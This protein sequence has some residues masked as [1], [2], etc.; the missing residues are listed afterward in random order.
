ML[1]ITL[2]D[3]TSSFSIDAVRSKIAKFQNTDEYQVEVDKNL[4]YIRQDLNEKYSELKETNDVLCGIYQKL[5]ET[6]KTGLG[7]AED[8]RETIDEIRQL[9]QEMEEAL[10]NYATTGWGSGKTFEEMF[11]E[12]FMPFIEALDALADPISQLG[13]GEIPLINQ[14]PELIKKFMTMGKIV[15]KLP[16]EIRNQAIAQAKQAKEEL[17]KSYAEQREAAGA[18][19]TWKRLEYDY[20]NSDSIVWRLIREIVEIV[21]A[22]FEM[23]EAICSCIEIFAILIIIDKFKPVIDQFKIMVGDA[24]TILENVETLLKCLIT[25]KYSMLK[26]LGKV[27]WSKIEGLIDFFTYVCTDMD[28]PSNALI[29]ACYM[30]LISCQCDISSLQLSVDYFE[31]ESRATY[32]KNAK[33]KCAEE[34]KNTEKRINALKKKKIPVPAKIQLQENVKSYLENLQEHL[35]SSENENLSAS[36]LIKLNIDSFEGNKSQTFKSLLAE[37]TSQDEYLNPKP[38]KESSENKDNAS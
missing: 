25:G 4:K 35:I 21:K 13:L 28:L 2:N 26:L 33:I 34:I 1:D 11:D 31:A 30:D 36:A 37:K 5:N 38:K 27:L 9:R 16:P 15:S 10:M 29:S 3:F 22:L 20:E 19:T 8:I 12:L 32:T 7:A 14:I 17:K 6:Q 24:I 23:I 18:N